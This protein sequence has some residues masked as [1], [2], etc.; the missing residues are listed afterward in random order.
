MIM[1]LRLIL[2]LV[3]IV[4]SMMLFA[5]NE[6]YDPALAEKLGA[7]EHGMR[8][9]QFVLLTSGPA[10]DLSKE[11]RDSLFTGHMQNIKRLA[12]EGKLVVA[13]PFGKNDR[14]RGLFIFTTNTKEETESLLLTDPAING[15]A[16][17]Y[18]IY[19]WYGSAALVEVVN[20][21]ERISRK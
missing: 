16:F 7:D 1:F 20:I 5:Q 21:H 15:G 18:E 19:P 10:R 8:S 4:G 3:S 2:F 9:Y 12:D 6:N 17:A 13:G 14:Y 11:V